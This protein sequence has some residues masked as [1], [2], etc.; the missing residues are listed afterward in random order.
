MKD[1]EL[2]ESILKVTREHPEY[3]YNYKQ[4]AAVLGVKDAFVRKRIVTLLQ[5]LAK[6][7]VLKEIERG[8]YQIKEGNKELVGHIQTVSK[9][10]GYFMSPKIEKDIY[11]HPSNLK[12]VSY[13][14]LT[15]PTKA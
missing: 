3:S 10:G 8:K 15:L 7:G 6:N 5:Q 11:I 14:H 9:G 12:T 4:I 2:A 13:T 1:R